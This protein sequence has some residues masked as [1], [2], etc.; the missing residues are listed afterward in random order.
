[1][2]QQT[3]QKLLSTDEQ[4]LPSRAPGTD[5]WTKGAKMESA[6]CSG[7]K[8]RVGGQMVER[9]TEKEERGP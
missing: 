8:Q 6:E 5:S 9:E 2:P 3:P 1:M 7:Q 4:R